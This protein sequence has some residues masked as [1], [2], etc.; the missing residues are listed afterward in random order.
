MYNPRFP[1]TLRVIRPKFDVSGVPE[2]DDNGDVIYEPVQLQLV[3][4]MDGEP[5]LTLEGEFQTYEADEVNFGYRI[6][7]EAT[8]TV[9]DVIVSDFRV[10]CPMFLTELKPG[11]ILEIKDYERSYQGKVVK[12]TTYNLGTVIWYNEIKN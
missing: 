11:D 7:T 10:D 5:M 12:K 8:R 9:T 6:S 3:D 4:M 1:H 2:V